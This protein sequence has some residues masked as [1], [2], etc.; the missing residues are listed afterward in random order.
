MSDPP[1]PPPPRTGMSGLYANLLDPSNNKTTSASISR[2]PIVFKQSAAASSPTPVTSTPAE[3]PAPKKLNAAALRF[4]PTLKRPTG[5]TVKGKGKNVRKPGVSATAA[6]AVGVT[7]GTA[8]TSADTAEG[9]GGPG[10]GGVA[11]PTVKTTIE[12]WTGD[13]DD[14]V[15]G[16]YANNRDQHRGVR[17]KRKKNRDT[18]PPPTNWDDVYD[19]SRPN[20]YDEY[21]DGDEKIRELEDWRDRVLPRRR[22]DSYDSEENE[23]ERDRDRQGLGNRFAPPTKYSF[24][25]PPQ[26]S[27]GDGGAG[28]LP[29]PPPPAAATGPPVAVP[30]DASGEDAYARRLRMSQLGSAG[31]SSTTST[32][33]EP[34]P[35]P[36]PPPPPSADPTP[37]PTISRAPVLY[38]TPQPPTDTPT[39][40]PTDEPTD[41]S[42][43]S[44]PSNPLLPGQKD[45]AARLMSK[46]G[47]RAGTGLGASST[48]ITQPLRAVHT[49]SKDHPTRG[50]IIDK[51]KPNP[52]ATAGKF[53]PA[54]VVVVLRHMVD[55]LEGEDEAVLMQEIGDECENSYG[56]VERVLV[57]WGKDDG[58][59]DNA[60][61]KAASRVF[62]KFSGELAALRAVNALEGRLFNG[63]TIEARFFDKDK[64]ED[65]EFD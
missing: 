65:R 43:P 17:K 12:D 60:G 59:G 20:S 37:Q 53:G 51:N 44:P 13:A 52:A 23:R 27:G 6:A 40:T 18:P 8:D 28:V 61:E 3:D 5:A 21:K 33:S 35:P 9:G 30:D 14:D 11:R 10:L 31:Y 42:P 54:S 32:T 39:D 2:A 24:A 49:K 26:L 29:P 56:G 34:P 36:P 4:Q 63:N 25:P 46:L 41:Q 47:W 22:R 1:P 48:G 62:V 64:F 38:T 7:T 19:P 58:E 50:K 16:F 15:N 57:V 45:F 55:G